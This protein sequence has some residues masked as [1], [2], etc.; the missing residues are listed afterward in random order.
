MS[1]GIYSIEFY[2]TEFLN[3]DFLWRC[4]CFSTNFFYC[5]YIVLTITDYHRIFF[6]QTYLLNKIFSNCFVFK[7]NISHAWN[8]NNNQLYF[9]KIYFIKIT[10]FK[11]EDFS[12]NLYLMIEKF[13]SRS[14]EIQSR[15]NIYKA[16]GQRKLCVIRA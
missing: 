2:V 13:S 7:N 14:K 1:S 3:N 6:N 4:I 11:T 12:Y 8:I 5:Y 16:P 10:E 15:S 9:I